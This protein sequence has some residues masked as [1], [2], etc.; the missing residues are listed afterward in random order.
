[1]KDREYKDA[2]EELKKSLMKKYTKFS[3]KEEAS[4]GIREQSELF[5]VV[6]ILYKMDKLDDSDEFNSLLDDLGD[7]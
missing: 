2:W 4:V 7:E 5:M 3:E 1:M 6:N